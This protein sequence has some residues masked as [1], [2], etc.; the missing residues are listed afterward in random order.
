M[1]NKVIIINYSFKLGLKSHVYWYGVSFESQPKSIVQ[2]IEGPMLG[3]FPAKE[4]FVM[5]AGY[6][7]PHCCSI[8]AALG[9]PRWTTTNLKDMKNHA[10]EMQFDVE[11]KLL[12]KK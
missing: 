1:I 9:L 2:D 10:A 4:G 8:A 3:R 12:E 6:L 7:P 11:K 5:L